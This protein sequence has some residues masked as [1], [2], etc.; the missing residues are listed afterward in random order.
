[1]E[2]KRSISCWRSVSIWNWSCASGFANISYVC[3]TWRRCNSTAIPI[4]GQELC[5][6]PRACAQETKDGKFKKTWLLRGLNFVRLFDQ[7]II[8]AYIYSSSET[9][10]NLGIF[11]VFPYRSSSQY[12]VTNFVY[13]EK[14]TW[15][16]L[17]LKS[18][19]KN[20]HF[21]FF[22]DWKFHLV[23]SKD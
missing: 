21:W 20:K 15:C 19:F 12:R 8:F 6:S 11:F 18:Q 7:L 2:R 4:V 10:D 22:S 9:Q 5:S 23:A 1:M 13:P 16:N 17:R 3:R 14:D